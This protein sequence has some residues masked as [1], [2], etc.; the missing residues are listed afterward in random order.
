ME[1][2]TEGTA[3]EN[4]TICP[5]HAPTS[6]ASRPGQVALSAPAESHDEDG[7]RMQM[8]DNLTLTGVQ[9]GLVES[10][11]KDTSSTYSSLDMQVHHLQQEVTALKA[12]LDQATYV[13]ESIALHLFTQLAASMTGA[14]AG[15]P[16]AGD[17]QGHFGRCAL[18]GEYASGWAT[19]GSSTGLLATVQDEELLKSLLLSSEP[20][21]QLMPDNGKLIGTHG[22]AQTSLES[23][24]Q[25]DPSR[26]LRRTRVCDDEV[27]TAT[28]ALNDLA[29]LWMLRQFG[30]PATTG[31]RATGE[32]GSR[33]TSALGSG[34]R[35][36]CSPGQEAA[37]QENVKCV[38]EAS[39]VATIPDVH[40]KEPDRL[41]PEVAA[42]MLDDQTLRES[43]VLDRASMEAIASESTWYC[44]VCHSLASDGLP[45]EHFCRSKSGARVQ[46]NYCRK[47]TARM[48][49]L[50]VHFRKIVYCKAVRAKILTIFQSV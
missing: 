10:G 35:D 9:K 6:P 4:E 18:N 19:N 3:R 26:R 45:G 21:P 27:T 48:P 24:S 23:L 20:H 14:P 36:K 40:G 1:D 8:A 13:N 33:P 16:R 44:R 31:Y 43:Y 15:P 46:C 39:T 30:V 17:G 22:R 37:D 29:E 42:D 49:D 7:S 50:R 34:S 2:P 12:K 25:S 41:M 11:L 5:A 32:G 38:A 47:T 28:E